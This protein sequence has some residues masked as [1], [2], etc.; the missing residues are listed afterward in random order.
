MSNNTTL[1]T[2][3]GGDSIRDIDKGGVKTQV[4]TLDVGGAGAETL[5]A[6]TV[7]VSGTV[8]ANVGTTGGLALDAT[9]SANQPRTVNLIT[10]F[11]LEAGHL[12]TIDTSTAKIPAQGQALAA[13]SMPVVLTAAQVT[14]LTPPA[15]ITG[16]ALEA[17]HLATIDTSA[18]KIPSQGQALMAAS[19]PVV[20]ASNQSAVPVSGTFWQATQPV[21]IAT[22]PSTP[23][24]G[25]FWQATQ[26]V[27][28][29]VTVTPPTLT[30][31]TQGATG[32]SVQSLK[33]AGRTYINF[34]VDRIAGV[35]TEALVT[36]T[37]NKNG[38][39][40]TGTSYTVTAGK[41]LR[42]QNLSCEILNTT[43]T[44]NRVTVRVR[45]AGSGAVS[46][47]S[48]VV[49]GTSAAA[50]AALATSGASSEESYPD[51]IELPSATIFG[52]T[53]LCS[54]TTAGVV[55]AQLIGYEY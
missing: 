10:G 14:T 44:A 42:I 28:G 24:T 51:G 7:P 41:T 31:D 18:A 27:S 8:T 40:T 32:F 19:T 5:L 46:A 45:S 38:A 15:A 1:N 4:V 13:A 36:M 2:G 3:A 16:F 30:K 33:D 43:T 50:V 37:I 20:I 35:T 6:G 39:T 34:Y 52:I 12:A 49:C 55:S 22:M 53:Q 25:T 17:G 48:P 23:V 11:A 26:P 29:T 54:V 21:S 47:T 9:V